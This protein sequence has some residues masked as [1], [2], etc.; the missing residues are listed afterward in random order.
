M[1]K[2]WM[3]GALAEPWVMTAA[4]VICMLAA[5]SFPILGVLRE[6]RN[7]RFIRDRAELVARD[8]DVRSI[9]ALMDTLTLDDGASRNLAVDA[10]IRLL[11]QL[12]Q[13]DRHRLSPAQHGRLIGYLSQDVESPL[14]KDLTGVFHPAA[15]RGVEFRVAILKALEQIGDSRSLPVVMRLAAM[16]ART[17]A[18]REVQRAAI[19]CLPYLEVLAGREREAQRLLRPSCSSEDPGQS[20]LRSA[21]PN[22]SSEPAVLLRASAGESTSA[23]T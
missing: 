17:A 2:E 9:G 11:P 8:G 13:S 20:L 16:P 21:A 10:L 6:F 1:S 5:T 4:L 3:I 18:Q 15:P 14:Y 19:D 22:V 12:N 23:S 7:R